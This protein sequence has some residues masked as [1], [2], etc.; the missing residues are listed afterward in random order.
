MLLL[1]KTRLITYQALWKTPFHFS[2]TLSYHKKRYVNDLLF[3]LTNSSTGSAWT[4]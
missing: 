2:L 4:D 1:L 3:L